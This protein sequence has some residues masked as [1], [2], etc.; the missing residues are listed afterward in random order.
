VGDRGMES[1]K[2][3]AVCGRCGEKYASLKQVEVVKKKL[4]N[5]K[6]NEILNLCSACRK[7]RVTENFKNTGGIDV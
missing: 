3:L 7:I 4:K 5:D 2:G 1:K 6:L